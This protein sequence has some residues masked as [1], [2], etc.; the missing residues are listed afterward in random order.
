MACVYV[1]DDFDYCLKQFCKA[2][3]SSLTTLRYMLE[4]KWCKGPVEADESMIP[5]LPSNMS[6]GLTTTLRYEKR[7]ESSI[8]KS[9][10]KIL[11]FFM[12]F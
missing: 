2:E 6:H 3:K 8:K 12:F 7:E 1:L 5:D 9:N 11:C 10:D 4:T